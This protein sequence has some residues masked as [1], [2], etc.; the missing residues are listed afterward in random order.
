MRYW[1]PTPFRTSREIRAEGHRH[2]ELGSRLTSVP[3][4]VV[5]LPTGLTVQPGQQVRRGPRVSRTDRSWGVWM[6]QSRMAL[7]RP[8]CIEEALCP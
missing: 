2:I 3:M 6:G 8:Y 1:S 7:C 5:S 4:S